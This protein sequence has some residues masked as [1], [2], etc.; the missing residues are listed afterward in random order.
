[1]NQAARWQPYPAYKDSGV[2]WLGRI[3]VH[4]EVKQLKYATKINQ[5]V[6]AETTNP[7]YLIQYIDIS[8]VDSN[9]QV[10]NIQEMPFSD[11]PSRARRKV[12]DGDTV[13]STVRTYLKAIALIKKP[14]KNWIVSTGFAVLSPNGEVLPEY[15][16]RLVQSDGFV[17]AVVTYSE[18]V[19][20][21]AITP[22]NLASLPVWIPPLPEQRAI[23]AY[24]DRETAKI[25]ALIA[26]KRRLIDLLQEKRAALISR[27]VTRGLNPS[28]PLKDSGV[29]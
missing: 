2:E 26:K 14:P 20:Y 18:G 21:P 17:N 5:E 24:L 11:A 23:A 13:I 27:A 12:Y 6:I 7:D 22:N 10:L 4:W 9:G 15:L 16:W 8:N 29:P 19:G 25:D 3:P 28:A 1:M